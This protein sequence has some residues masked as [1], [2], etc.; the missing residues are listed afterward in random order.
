MDL[1][2]S[3]MVCTKQKA[4]AEN[5]GVRSPKFFKIRSEMKIHNSL[6]AI[7]LPAYGGRMHRFA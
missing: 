3:I 6:G 7:M 2:K 1:P 4:T 5:D